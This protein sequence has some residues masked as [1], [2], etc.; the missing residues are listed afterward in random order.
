MSDR[1]PRLRLTQARRTRAASCNSKG[2]L[3][4]GTL[5]RDAEVT[6]PDW[7]GTAQLDQRMT[8]ASLEQVVGLDRD[9]WHIRIVA[10]GD[11]R[12]QD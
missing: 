6:Y 1:L 3:I 8:P 12:E 5:W 9:E 11:V 4:D 10:L 2:R 7:N